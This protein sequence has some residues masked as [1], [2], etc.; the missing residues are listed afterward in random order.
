MGDNPFR[1][2]DFLIRIASRDEPTQ[3]IAV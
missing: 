1:A 3:L 2:E